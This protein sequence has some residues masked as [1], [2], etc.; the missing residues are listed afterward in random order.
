MVL[1]LPV[2][3]LL[4]SL[5]TEQIRKLTQGYELSLCFVYLAAGG[6]LSPNQKLLTIISRL[7]GISTTCVFWVEFSLVS[8]WLYTHV[9]GRS[10]DLRSACLFPGEWAHSAL[11]LFFYCSQINNTQPFFVCWSHCF[12]KKAAWPRR[13]AQINPSS[14]STLSACVH[15]LTPVKNFP[16][17]S[18]L[19][20]PVWALQQDT[21]V[22]WKHVWNAWQTLQRNDTLITC[23]LKGCWVMNTY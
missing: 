10:A 18:A 15:G 7:Q 8:P 11:F 2:A 1:L 23:P 17:S 9:V 6:A 19:V 22:K 5:K 3:W 20:Q 12:D 13:P 14:D 21:S 16:C 4:M